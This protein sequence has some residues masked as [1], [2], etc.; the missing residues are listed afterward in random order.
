MARIGLVAGYGEL[1]IIF[2]RNAKA[3]GD[4]V[5]ALGLK[6]VTSE[7]LSKYADKVHWF[8]WGDL[9]KAILL[10]VTERIRKVTLLGKIKKEVLFKD[11]EKLDEE[12]K[13]IVKAA[14][15]KK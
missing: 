8:E 12:A 15:G 6:G 3:K 1:P 14:G 9:K 2:A 5:I 4:I 11:S 7:E 13:K 10:T